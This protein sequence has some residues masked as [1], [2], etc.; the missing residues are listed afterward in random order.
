MGTLPSTDGTATTAEPA[1]EI[2]PATV[3]DKP[4]R[5]PTAATIAAPMNATPTIAGASSFKSLTTAADAMRDEEVERTRLFIRMGWVISLASM[6]VVPILVAPLVTQIAMV[7]AMVLGMVVSFVYHQ[8]FADPAK[9]NEQA[10]LRL[11]VMCIVNAHVAVLY[12]GAFTISPIIVVIGIH[13]VARTEAERAARVLYVT[14]L[15]CYSVIAIPIVTGIADDP[16]VFATAAPLATVTRLIGA[17]FVLGTYTLAYATARVFRRASLASIDELALATRLASQREALMD[18]LRA[19]LERA[20]R[21]GGPGRYTDQTFGKWHLGVLLGRGAIGEVYE[22]VNVTTRE[23]AAV[24]LLRREMLADPTQ[25]ARFLREARAGGALASPFVVRVLDAS[26]EDASPPF[27]AME[28]LRGTTLAEILR[29]D[30]R[31]EPKAVAD[32]LREAGAGVDAATA[33]NIVHRDLKPQNLFHSDG[34]GWKVLD[35]G[36]ASLTEDSGA[37]TQGGVVGTPAYMAPEQA[38]GK[39]VTARADVYALA[40]V[41]YRCLTGRHP[42]HGPDTPSLLYAVVHR[43]PVRPGAL[44]DLHADVDAAFAIALAKDPDDRFASG[45]AL[46]AAI[47]QALA[48]TLPAA[49]RA[50][51]A[52]LAKKHPWEL[53]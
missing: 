14:A 24:K 50:R 47:E 2:E 28:R 13:F 37:L 7:A 11:A 20:L 30:T 36:A 27:L 51:G 12:F 21:V 18:E 39:K 26:P 1:T 16:G 19:D 52:Q 29:R 40:A 10:L 49:T 38:Q 33:A 17:A 9:Y 5:A 45:A 8:R 44:A 32:L 35:F 6:G 43:M 4:Q 34:G 46:A 3:I 22:A 23:P 41:A 53:A 31:L 25:I 42:F 48:G 15:A